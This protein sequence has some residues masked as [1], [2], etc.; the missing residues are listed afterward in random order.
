M[1]TLSATQ[2]RKDF[3]DLIRRTLRG[4][5]AVRIVHRDGPVVLL[6][7]GDY[8]GLLE[9]LELLSV[10]GFRDG[11]AEAEADIEA[12]RT[13]SVHEVFGDD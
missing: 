10:P 12:G 13:F 7:E 1:N 11:L 5:E 6:S 4:H 3:F 8:E 2:A 9:T